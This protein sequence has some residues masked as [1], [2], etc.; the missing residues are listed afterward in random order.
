MKYRIICKRNG[1]FSF[2]YYV[3]LVQ[4]RTEYVGCVGY[5]NYESAERAAK[6]TGA[7]KQERA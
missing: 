1:S 3:V 4:A 2:L 5:R 6:R 7:T